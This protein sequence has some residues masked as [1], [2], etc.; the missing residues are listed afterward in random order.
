MILERLVILQRPMMLEGLVM[1]M[2]HDLQLPARSS[3]KP[4]S[5]RPGFAGA[6]GSG[7][8][9]GNGGAAARVRR[10]NASVC[11]CV[12]C[13]SS[14]RCLVVRVRMG[15]GA[16][17]VAQILQILEVR[18]VVI[19]VARLVARSA[20]ARQPLRNGSSRSSAHGGPA[21]APRAPCARSRRIGASGALEV[22]MLADRVV[23]QT[24]V[25]KRNELSSSAATADRSPAPGIAT[26]PTARPHL[27]TR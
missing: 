27:R 13:A 20:N 15:C 3:W 10:T 7:S 1:Q 5:C 16:V 11:S 26:L 17:V 4:G 18:D 6:G 14:S 22:E 9:A 19:G 24:H 25:A 2:G 23:Q 8:C 12:R 21:Q